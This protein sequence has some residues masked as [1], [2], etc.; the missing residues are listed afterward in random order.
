MLPIGNFHRVRI[1]FGTSDNLDRRI[2]VDVAGREERDEDRTPGCGQKNVGQI[3][4]YAFAV[5]RF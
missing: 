1:N 2:L 5:L 4:Y 3:R